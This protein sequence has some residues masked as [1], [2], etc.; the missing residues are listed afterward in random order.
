V[1]GDLPPKMEKGYRRLRTGLA[2]SGDDGCLQMP[3]VDVTIETGM[4]DGAL[5]PHPDLG[6]DP[7][8]GCIVGMDDRDEFVEAE[9]PKCVIARRD[10]G[11]RGQTAPPRVPRQAPAE[12]RPSGE[13]REEGGVAESDEADEA[14]RSRSSRDSTAKKPKPCFSQC[15][16][17]RPMKSTAG[18]SGGLRYRATSG[19]ASMDARATSS[20]GC[21]R[22]SA[23]R[24]VRRIGSPSIAMQRY[25]STR[26]DLRSRRRPRAHAAP[27]RPPGP[28]GI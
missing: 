16:M 24:G 21:Q 1:F 18:G 11:L 6:R 5:D 12:L 20:P 9:P 23:G 14:A 27:S 15:S 3:D 4:F 17:E 13:V 8:R 28:D 25:G 19:S 7:P 22:R 26:A 10:G 2:D